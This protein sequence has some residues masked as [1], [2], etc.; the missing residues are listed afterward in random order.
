MYGLN[1]LRTFLA[2]HR[3]G[4]FTAAASLLGLSQ[5]TVTAQIRALE[6][7]TAREL[8]ERR[9]RGVVPT[10]AADELAVRVA[11]PSTP[12]PRQPAIRP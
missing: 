6:Q 2:V 7:Q 1:L 8:F 5:P 4:S 9:P 10:P 12:S 11:A 3:A